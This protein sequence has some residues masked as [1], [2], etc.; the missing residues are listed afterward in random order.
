MAVGDIK[1][2]TLKIGDIDLTKYKDGSCAGFNIYEDIL[3]PYGPVCEI[4]VVDHSDSLGQKKFTGSFDQDIEI[5]FSGDDNILSGGGSSKYKLKPFHNK[6]LNDQSVN[7]QGSG[8]HKQYDVRAVSEELLNAQGNYI[9]KAWNDKTSKMVEDVLKDGFKTKKQIDI[10]E[11]TK[12]KKKFRV[13]NKH[14]LEALHM[15][16]QEHVS[17]ENKSSAFVLFQ[18]PDQGEHKYVFATF[19]KLFQE[20]SKVKLKQTTVLDYE[21]VNEKDKQNSIMWFRPSDNFFTPTRS[22]SKS[23]EYTYNHTTHRISTVE[24]KDNQ[25]KFAEREGWYKDQADYAKEV[26]VH[27]IHDKA[28]YKDKHETSEARTNRAQYLSHLAQDCAEFECYYNPEIKLG[29]MIDL[30]IP[31]KA[32]DEQEKGEQFFNGECLV[33]AIRTKYRIDKRPFCTQVVRVVK[34]SPKRGGGKSA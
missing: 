6:N 9:Q 28:N 33:A 3:N 21:G 25:F 17:D 18:Q 12:G 5:E 4:R 29:A 22:L 14:P 27:T 31:L 26:P 1:I 10:K 23:S 8:K 32:N 11:K 15:L 30:E 19:E 7:N 2:K 24:P 16:N 13:D 34:A 20:E